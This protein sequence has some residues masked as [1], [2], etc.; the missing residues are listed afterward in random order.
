[1]SSTRKRLALGVAATI[2]VIILIAAF[3]SS[4]DPDP[5]YQGKKL[6]QWMDDFAARKPSQFNEAVREIGTNSLP[7]VVHNLAK[8]D[9]E[10]HLRYRVLWEKTPAKIQKYLPAPRPLLQPVHGAN[11]F[12][13][14]GTNSLP[15]AIALLQHPSSTV[16]QSAA[17]GI[18]TLRRQSEA[19]NQ[20]IPA[21]TIALADSEKQVRFYALLAFKEMGAAASNAVP[22]ITKILAGTPQPG[23][24]DFY[25]RA[26]AA[27]ALGKI[28]PAAESSLPAL[29]SA[30]QS[31][32]SYL[33]GQAA[34]AIWRVSGDVDTALPAL[35]QVMPAE[36]EHSKWDWIIAVGEMGPRAK[37]ALP[38]LKRELAADKQVWV[39]EYVT[40]ALRRIDPE[41]FPNKPEPERSSGASGGN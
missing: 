37:A 18:C 13:Y 2:T 33:C 28:G 19:A 35:L 7:R 4:Q 31:P 9:S 32:N 24:S 6:S 15:C 25:L 20:A 16:R 29:K 12:H 36:S 21:L 41:Y 17:W 23:G 11:V 30:L 5:L 14:I 8:N 10:I 26:A 3:F 38:Q 27:S 40:N 39:L 1:M 22:A 34:V